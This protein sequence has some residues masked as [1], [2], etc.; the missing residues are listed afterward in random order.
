[1]YYNVWDYLKI[2]WKKMSVCSGVRNCF[3]TCNKLYNFKTHSKANG[4]IYTRWSTA[5]KPTQMTIVSKITI[6]GMPIGHSIS[7]VYLLEDKIKWLLKTLNYTKDILYSLIRTIHR[8]SKYY[9]N[10]SIFRVIVRL[11]WKFNFFLFLV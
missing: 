9:W 1:M 5:Y 3:Q 10:N 6:I 11:G 7:W 8:T 4:M 2:E